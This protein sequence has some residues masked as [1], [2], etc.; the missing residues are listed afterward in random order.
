[1]EN[2]ENITEAFSA[3]EAKLDESEKS[4]AVFRL[5]HISR[6]KRIQELKARLSQR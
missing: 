2:I 3:L 5:H 6:Q 1:M 4:R